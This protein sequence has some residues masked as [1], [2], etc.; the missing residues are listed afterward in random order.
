MKQIFVIFAFLMLL[1][2]AGV[3]CLYVFE[4]M[5]YD[6]SM[7]IATKFGAAL[8]LLGICTAAVTFLMG[9]TKTSQD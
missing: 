9:R 1:L 7:D 3:G 6:A 2:I 5:T 8:L 4:V